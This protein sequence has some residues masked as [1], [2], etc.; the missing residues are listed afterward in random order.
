MKTLTVIM[1]AIGAFAMAN[2]PATDPNAAV[3]APS[4]EK[5]ASVSTK[6]TKEQKK[7]M[8]KCLKDAGKD[9]TKREACKTTPNS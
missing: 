8:R 2:P 1:F 6:L 5:T 7:A 9:A 3:G 4:G